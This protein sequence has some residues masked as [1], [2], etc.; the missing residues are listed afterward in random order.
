MQIVVKDRR[1]AKAE[2][3]QRVVEVVKR[4]TKI[5]SVELSGFLGIRFT[6]AKSMLETLEDKGILKSAMEKAPR[7]GLGRRYYELRITK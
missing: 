3:L 6:K 4:H 1:Q 7:S 5:Y 2:D